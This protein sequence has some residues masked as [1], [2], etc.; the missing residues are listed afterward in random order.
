LDWL[1][2]TKRIG[3]A[4]AMLNEACRK[5]LGNSVCGWSDNPLK[6]GPILENV[7][8]G[9]TIVKQHEADRD[10]PKLLAVPAA[11]RFLS[12]EPLLGPI[13]LNYAFGIPTGAGRG[14]CP[15][16]LAGIAPEGLRPIGQ[17]HLHWVIAGGESGPGARPMHPAWVRSLRDQCE[18]AGVSFF[19]KQWGE[20]QPRDHA[21][22][23]A[24]PEQEQAYLRADATEP[25]QLLSGDCMQF[26]RIG[27]KA[28]GCI[29]DGRTWD[30]VPDNA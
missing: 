12:I 19:F 24:D 14:S 21:T 8:I 13:D 25:G 16:R 5:V 1:L 23:G 3:N 29:L 2:L 28:A 6:S 26:S 18:A 7:W 17:H 4:H 11:K 15:M 22:T 20:W 10:I 30:E 9:A 27:K